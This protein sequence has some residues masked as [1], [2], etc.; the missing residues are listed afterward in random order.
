MHTLQV[1]ADSL[2]VGI[3]DTT[4]AR[5]AYPFLPEP[6]TQNLR[7]VSQIEEEDAWPLGRVFW[8]V[9]QPCTIARQS[10]LPTTYS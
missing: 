1:T 7:Q 6:A 9:R 5:A 8:I 10:T 4:L 2:T 3:Y